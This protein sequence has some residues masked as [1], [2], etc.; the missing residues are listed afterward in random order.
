[1][2]SGEKE[3]R[4]ADLSRNYLYEVDLHDAHLESDLSFRRG[5]PS[6]GSLDKLRG[7][8]P[9]MCV[10]SPCCLTKVKKGKARIFI[11]DSLALNTHSIE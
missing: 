9:E 10:K 1:M 8:S 11:T 7:R 4:R 6:S 2:E 3:E 5:N